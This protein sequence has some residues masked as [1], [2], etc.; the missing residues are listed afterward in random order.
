MAIP[1]TPANSVASTESLT[2]SSV[3]Y[4]TPESVVRPR[5]LWPETENGGYSPSLLTSS[6]PSSPME[7]NTYEANSNEEEVTFLYELVDG[8]YI[9]E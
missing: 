2:P 8:V 6:P 5:L 3:G 1:M 4:P 9:I 7:L